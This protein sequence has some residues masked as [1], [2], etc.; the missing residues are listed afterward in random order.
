MKKQAKYWMPLLIIFFYMCPQTNAQSEREKRILDAFYTE[1]DLVVAVS[2]YPKPI[3]QVAENITIVTAREIEAMNAHTVAEVLNRVP[4]VFVN[5]TREFGAVS[6]INMQGSEA[7]HLLVLLDGVQW[8]FLGG[9]SAETSSIPVGIIERIE[10]IKGPASSAWGSSLGG[11]INIITKDVGTTRKPTGT[12]RFSAGEATSLDYSAQ[13]S[14]T[15]SNLGYYLYAG[16]QESD[17]LREDRNFDGNR[18]FSKFDLPVS[19]DIRMGFSVGYSEPDN[20]L[21]DFPRGDI[22][23]QSNLETFYAN[24]FLNSHLSNKIEL[25]FTGYYISQDVAFKN[26]LL[27][28]SPMGSAGELFQNSLYDEETY[29]GSGKLIWQNGSHTL[30]AGME[31]DHGELEQTILAGDFLQRYGAPATNKTTPDIDEWAFYINDTIVFGRWTITP[32]LRFDDNSVSGSFFSPSLGVTYQLQKNSVLRATVSRGFHYPPLS[33]S[34]G[35]GLFLDSNPSLDAEEVWS[36]QA[37][38]ETVIGAALWLKANLFFHDQAEAITGVSGGGGPPYFNDIYINSGEIERKGV[39]VE[40]KTKQILNFSVG[41]NGTYLHIDPANSSG[42]SE[43]WAC[44]LLLEYDDHQSIQAQLHGKY[45]DWDAHPVFQ[46][47]NDV[48]W[49]FNFVKKFPLR[50]PIRTDF[51]FTA[52]NVFNGSQYTNGDSKNPSRWIEAGLQWRY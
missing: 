35:G 36:Y 43:K 32:G 50:N 48:I 29:G 51:F 25:Q 13:M 26:T 21:G 20:D 27:G 42:S 9:G 49:D 45:M 19:S 16:R 14:G 31:L 7:R 2:R 6:L 17:G 34:Q 46:S 28:L 3:S 37:G 18:F 12:I 52:H 11:V 47:K 39:E 41:A 38:F 8:N 30:V 15:A 1:N 10:I 44:G 23:S 33:F 24:A 5:F 40:I 4:G 22:H